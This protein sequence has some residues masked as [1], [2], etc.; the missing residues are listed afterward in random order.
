MTHSPLTLRQIAKQV[1]DDAI[2]M[3]IQDLITDITAKKRMEKIRARA[4][5]MAEEERRAAMQVCILLQVRQIISIL[6]GSIFP[7]YLYILPHLNPQ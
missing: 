6:S 1:T 7:N 4:E 2:G 5:L 3:F